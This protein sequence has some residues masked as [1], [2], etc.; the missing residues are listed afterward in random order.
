M[1]CDGES[2]APFVGKGNHIKSVAHGVNEITRG[3][4]AAGSDV[5]GKNL[6]PGPREGQ[7]HLSFVEPAHHQDLG[8]IPRGTSAACLPQRQPRA[9]GDRRRVI[10]PMRLIAFRHEH[11]GRPGASRSA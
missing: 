3:R 4:A 11:A 5:G 6:M 7:R 2:D 1:I 9:P 10:R 8:Q